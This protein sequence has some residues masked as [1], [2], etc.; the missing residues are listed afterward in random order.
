M[1]T[2]QEC[3]I[4]AGVQAAAPGASRDYLVTVFKPLKSGA[5]YAL[6]LRVQVAQPIEWVRA[7]VDEIATRG[8]RQDRIAKDPNVPIVALNVEL[9]P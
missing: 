6:V 2:R 1:S 9:A 7:H 3:A 4:P 8:V 5:L